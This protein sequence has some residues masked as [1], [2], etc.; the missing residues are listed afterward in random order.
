MKIQIRNEQIKSQYL[1]KIIKKKWK[2]D[3][4]W[5]QI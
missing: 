1:L 3:L 5:Y 2:G 4:T